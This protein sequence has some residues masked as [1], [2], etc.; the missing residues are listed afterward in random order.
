MAGYRGE[1]TGR[2]DE[3]PAIEHIGSVRQV[4]HL[5]HRPVELIGELDVL[6]DGDAVAH[7]LLHIPVHLV[8]VAELMVRQRGDMDTAQVAHIQDDGTTLAGQ[9]SVDTEHVAELADERVRPHGYLVIAEKQETADIRLRQRG[10][11][12]GLVDAGQF[13]GIDRT[14]DVHEI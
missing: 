12:D 13:W 2:R 8:E 1:R 4:A 11:G 14:G 7:L 9:A 3:Q 6:G 5:H 10:D